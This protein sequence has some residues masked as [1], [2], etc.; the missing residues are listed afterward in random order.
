MRER[1]DIATRLIAAPRTPDGARYGPARA[2]RRPQ[3][4][5]RYGKPRSPPLRAWRPAWRAVWL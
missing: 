2:A 1:P 5:G 3:T 4:S